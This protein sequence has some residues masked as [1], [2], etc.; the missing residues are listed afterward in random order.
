MRVFKRFTLGLCAAAAAAVVLSPSGAFA[1]TDFEAV[2][3]DTGGCVLAVDQ[4]GAS[5]PPATAS[6]TISQAQTI[7]WDGRRTGGG[8]SACGAGAKFQLLFSP[9]GASSPTTIVL[10]TFSGTG[11][12]TGDIR[13]Q[14]GKYQID[15]SLFMG[16]GQYQVFFNRRLL[17]AVAPASASFGSVVGGSTSSSTSFTVR[18]GGDQG[19]F[20]VKVDQIA[21]GG[22][23]AGEFTVTSDSATGQSLR[24]SQS[25][26]VSAAC[27]ALPPTGSKGGSLGVSAHATE[28][29]TVTAS[30]SSALACTVTVPLACESAGW[31]VNHF[32]PLLALPSRVKLAKAVAKVT[33]TKATLTANPSNLFSLFGGP[34]T[35]SPNAAV[36]SGG[37]YVQQMSFNQHAAPYDGQLTASLQLDYTDAAGNSY[38]TTCPVTVTV[39]AKPLQPIGVKPHPLH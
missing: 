35:V 14:P 38:S 3:T 15:T 6:F 13:L 39:I 21:L 31:T 24:A 8:A 11:E 5:L 17:L 2:K 37:E 7:H 36:A 16:A 1:S 22:P 19:D 27:A 30:A 29:S 26:T 4:G 9:P 33:V 25:K 12:Q 34:T 20:T 32:A 23:N 18:N 28:D 10:A